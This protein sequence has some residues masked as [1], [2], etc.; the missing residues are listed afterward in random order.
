MKLRVRRIEADDLTLRVKWFN[1]PM[2]H[3]QMPLNVPMSLAE[4]QQWFART[5]LNERRQDVVFLDENP[6]G[7]SRIVAMG[8]LVDIDRTHRRA[9]LYLVVDPD[10]T[11]RGIGRVALEWLCNQGF[12]RLGLERIYL[13]TLASNSRARKFYERAGFVPEGILRKHLLHRGELVDRHVH[14]MLRSEW[15]E[16]PWHREAELVIGS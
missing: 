10:L 1:T 6:E 7:K 2:I 14:G 3:E 8:G 9:E 4:T 16:L 15:Q 12:S 11:G 5:L 13:F